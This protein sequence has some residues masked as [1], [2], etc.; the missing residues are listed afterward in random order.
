VP[1]A[2]AP[3]S[4]LA[5]A[6]VVAHS[7]GRNVDPFGTAQAFTRV[8]AYA[9]FRITPRALLSLRGYDP[10]YDYHALIDDLSG[11]RFNRAAPEQSLMLLKATGMVPH[12]GGR[13]FKP[14]SE[15]YRTILH[16]IQAGAPDDVENVPQVTGISLVPDKIVFAGKQTRHPLRIVIEFGKRGTQ[17]FFFGTNHGEI[18]GQEHDQQRKPEP[19]GV[20]GYGEAYADENGSEIQRLRD[21][22]V[23]S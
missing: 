16:W 6:G 13:R 10:D 19:D 7:V 15:Y 14:D 21:P 20:G 9:R 5:S 11:R 18:D 2:G 1:S 12:S 22:S 17:E 3:A 4:A 23:G 8:D